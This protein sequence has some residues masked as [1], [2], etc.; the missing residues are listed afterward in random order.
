MSFPPPDMRTLVASQQVNL[1][2]APIPD[3]P[4]DLEWV[5]AY[6]VQRMLSHASWA[7]AYL[8]WIIIGLVYLIY[9]FTRW[10]GLNNSYLAAVWH[11]WALRRRTWRKKHTLALALRKGYEH[12]QPLSLP[13]NAHLLAVA[14]LWIGA[15]LISFIGP[16]SM[17]PGSFFRNVKD[18]PT[19]HARGFNAANYYYL[20]PKFT[21][22]KMWY[23]SSNRTGLIAFALFPLTVLFAL[24]APPFAIFAIPQ[25]THICFDKL[26]FMHRWCAFLVWLLTT[27]HVILWCVQLAIDHKSGHNGFHFAW[28][29]TK[30]RYAWTVSLVTLSCVERRV[31]RRVLPTRRTFCSLY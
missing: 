28:L 7:Y 20:Q 26:A 9:S 5:T 19:L 4:S 16:D 12:R 18:F 6:L 24:K 31:I 10:T 15:I 13:P 21:I 2:Y 27:L 30:F 23:T 1:T 8:V 25:F 11:T 17:A 22:T 14:L 3:Y 29:Y